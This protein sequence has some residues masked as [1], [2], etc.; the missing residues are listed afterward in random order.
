M[1]IIS[2]KRKDKMQNKIDSIRLAQQEEL[3][4][5]GATCDNCSKV[6]TKYC[7]N[8]TIKNPC[9]YHTGPNGKHT[10]SF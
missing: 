5:M 2:P 7:N 10:R 4:E 9:V 8:L 1:G 3:I 6:R